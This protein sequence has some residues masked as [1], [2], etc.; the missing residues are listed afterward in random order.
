MKPTVRGRVAS[1][2]AAALALLV[3]LT[4][5]V[6]NPFRKAAPAAPLN[7]QPPPGVAAPAHTLP[8]AS[9][10]TPVPSYVDIDGRQ[11]SAALN[12]SREE[13]QVM[14]DEISALREQLASTSSQLAQARVAGMPP[15]PS[16]TTV[17]GLK[18]TPPATMK[19]AL[20]DLALPGLSPRLDGSVVRIDIP[21]D[22]LF[23]DGTANI[24]SAG[25]ALLTQV[26]TELERVYPGHFIGI[27]GH[28]DT[29]P[30][31]NASWTS[32]HQLTAARAAAVFDFLTTRTSMQERQLFLVAHGANHPLVSNATAAGRAKNRRIELVVYPEHSAAAN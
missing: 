11:V 24:R 7:L 17:A 8:Q 3:S 2:T 18:A 32:P 21:A 10:A 29:E 30:L 13:S 1:A 23:D 9:L 6:N 20:A 19:S 4:G 15:G 28:V 31:Q 27:E 25:A 5:C 16:A 26:S 14:Q 12:R 22:Q